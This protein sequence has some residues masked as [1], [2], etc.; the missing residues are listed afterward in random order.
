MLPAQKQVVVSGSPFAQQQF[1][2]KLHYALTTDYRAKWRENGI[3]YG[4]KPK[5]LPNAGSGQR[6]D[7]GKDNIK[8]RQ[9]FDCCVR[10]F[11]PL[12]VASIRAITRHHPGLSHRLQTHFP[13]G[14]HLTIQAHL[15]LGKARI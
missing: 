15:S 11:R 10:G 12:R 14:I 1:N 8:Y 9:S 6:P 3:E 13:L 7:R 4:K 5:A 2:Q